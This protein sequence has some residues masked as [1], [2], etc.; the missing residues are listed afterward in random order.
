METQSHDDTES[1]LKE[2]ELKKRELIKERAKLHTEKLEYNRWL[3]EDARD[4]LFEE[5]SLLLFTKH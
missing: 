3:R 5:K 2:L 4:D 1:Y